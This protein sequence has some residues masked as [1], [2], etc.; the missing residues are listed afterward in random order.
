MKEKNNRNSV[1]MARQT[2]FHYFYLHIYAYRAA[3]Q[4]RKGHLQNMVGKGRFYSRIKCTM[5]IL[6]ALFERGKYVAIHKEGLVI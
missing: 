3:K 6:V 4:Y 1:G 2:R 5:R